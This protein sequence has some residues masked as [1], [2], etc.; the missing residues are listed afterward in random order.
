MQKKYFAYENPNQLITSFWSEN[1]ADFDSK[2][3]IHLNEYRAVLGAHASGLIGVRMKGRSP[4]DGCSIDGPIDDGAEINQ[5]SISTMEI[6]YGHYA[7]WMG[8]I[9]YIYVLC[10]RMKGYAHVWPTTCRFNVAVVILKCAGYFWI[11]CMGSDWNVGI[12]FNFSG[13][14]NIFFI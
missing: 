1:N 4:A 2:H 12:Y 14:C 13:R 7:R 5:A 3:L 8:R 10:V 11:L 9:M 6:R